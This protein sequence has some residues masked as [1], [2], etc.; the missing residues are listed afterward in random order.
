MSNDLV[1]EEKSMWTPPL[2]RN[3]GEELVKTGEN[4]HTVSQTLKQTN[5]ALEQMVKV[6]KE[7]IE[8]MDSTGKSLNMA[9]KT[10]NVI[11]VPKVTIIPLKVTEVSVFGP[12]GNAL[13]DAGYQLNA[14]K[15]RLTTIEKNMDNI[16]KAKGPL[17]MITTDVLDPLSNRLTALGKNLVQ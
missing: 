5:A 14:I 6:M 17:D 12:T 13:I 8:F 4:I 7:I 9:G 2:M 10:I 16:S 1:S 3:I 15:E 11:T